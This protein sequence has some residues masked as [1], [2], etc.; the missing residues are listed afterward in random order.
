MLKR[1]IHSKSDIELIKYYKL[2]DDPEIIGELFKRYTGFVFAI[3]MRYLKNQDACNDAVMGIFEELFEKLKQHEIS[4]F[5]SWLH[6]LTRNYCL[7]QLRSQ[8][9]TSR[10]N[11]VFEKE[12]KEFMEDTELV[13]QE[14]DWLEEKLQLMEICI[15]KLKNE[16]K[17][18]VELFYIEKKSYVDISEQTG[19]ELKKVKS[20][21]QNGK[22]NLKILM[23]NYNE[24]QE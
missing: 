9:N 2:N 20:Y 6:T 13:H 11:Q 8:Q 22:R 18:C 15:P 4:N 24:R 17:L 7:L 21:I 1:K 19:F 10:K 23:E 12:Q 16:Q 3:S 14:S 5:K